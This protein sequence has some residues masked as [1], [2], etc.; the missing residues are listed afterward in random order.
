MAAV[1]FPNGG[2][3]QVAFEIYAD[4]YSVEEPKRLLLKLTQ[5]VPR[6]VDKHTPEIPDY[7]VIV[8]A[9]ANKLEADFK[10]VVEKLAD[11]YT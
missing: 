10:R 2:D 11:T 3:A 1:T 8:R 7:N 4:G 6:F 9:A 5:E